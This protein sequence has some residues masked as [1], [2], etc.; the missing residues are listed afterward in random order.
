M[1]SSL[2]S[3]SARCRLFTSE[4]V[5]VSVNWQP[6]AARDFIISSVGGNWDW[7][8]YASGLMFASLAV[9]ML[10]TR[11]LNRGQSVN[12][13]KVIAPPPMNTM[14]QL[15]AVQNA[16]S[17]VEQLIQ[18][19]NIGLLKVRAL[20]LSVFPQAS[21]KF[22]AA[23]LGMGLVLA[24]LPLKL[25][26]LLGFLEVSTRHSPSRKESSERC[27]RRMREWWFSIPAAPVVLD[28]DKDDKKKK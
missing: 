15:L 16:I 11:F 21:D 28:R 8:G 27:A 10:L 1:F 20:L 24:I 2:R 12:E 5:A 6:S 22:A 26:L 19:G 4:L 25:V 18:D 3:R 9:F 14:E 23:L 7:L 17:Q 13:L